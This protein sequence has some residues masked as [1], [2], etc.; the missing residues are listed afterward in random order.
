MKKTLLIHLLILCSAM[1]YAQN[2]NLVVFAEAGERFQ[3]ILNGVQYNS[4][5]E[6]NVK[7]E[8]LAE[9]P[10]KARIIFEDRTISP[11]EKTLYT[12]NNTETTYSVKFMG[13]SK[14]GSEA[15]KI[16][17]SMIKAIGNTDTYEEKGKEYK[18]K[19]VSQTPIQA[20]STSVQ[21]TTSQ[22]QTVSN[23]NVTQTTTTTTS[24]TG[25][26]TPTGTG[27]TFS[28]N[29]N[30]SENGNS[31]NVGMNVNVTES[32]STNAN[33]NMN[34]NESYSY[35][36]TTTTTVT[37]TSDNQNTVSSGGD[38][39][40]DYPMDN[41][42]FLEGKQSIESKTFSDSKMTM[43][44]QI[45]KNNCPTATQVRDY[46]KLF[47]YETDKLEYAKFAHD[48]C[49]DKG[50]YYKVNDAFEFESTIEELDE[51]ISGK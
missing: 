50:N 26:T 3:L 20:P 46:V 34:V 51:Y 11:L 8:H 44:K 35:T 42:D 21:Q 31:E 36:E 45:T 48:Y 15:K 7:V 23:T 37:S 6:T 10:F 2:C 40:C 29:V 17:N 24:T 12:A 18:I 49:Y 25:G 22:P 5:P 47:T 1:V 41:T 13:D 32:N 28:M 14:T 9:A 16:G 38:G 4:E 43:A 39:R 27:E 33:V 30:I 19:M